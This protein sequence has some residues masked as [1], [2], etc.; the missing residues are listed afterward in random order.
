MLVRLLRQSRPVS[1]KNP[2]FFP[3]N[4]STPPP[5]LPSLHW[6]LD[7]SESVLLVNVAVTL[8]LHPVLENHGDAE[9]EDEVD[10]D[11]SEGGGEDLVEISV[12][13][14][15]EGAD[16]ATLL[17]CDEGVCARAVLDEGGCCCVDVAA[18]VELVWIS[19]SLLSMIQGRLIV[20]TFCCS[21]LWMCGVSRPQSRLRLWRVCR[22]SIQ[23]ATPSP[24]VNTAQTMMSAA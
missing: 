23:M 17:G 2:L 9:H 13:E 5:A 16:A 4:N 22:V 18:A 8:L 21:R 10:A 6:N 11:D 19:M 14:G 3:L 1:S 15:R 12:G 7:A 24:R 20:H